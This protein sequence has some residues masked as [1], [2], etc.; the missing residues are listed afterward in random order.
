MFTKID[1][2]PSYHHIRVKDEHI[3]KMVFRTRYEHYEYSVMTFGVLNA[4]GVFMEYMNCIFHPYL[5]Q[6]L[7][8][9]INNSDLF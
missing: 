3:Q 6:L 8:V 1:L 7:I 5:D 9:F 4:P 2:R